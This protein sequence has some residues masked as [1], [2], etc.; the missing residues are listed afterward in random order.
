MVA[1]WLNA[2]AIASLWIALACALYVLVDVV[3]HPQGMA[4]MNWVWPITALYAGPLAVWAYFAWGKASAKPRAAGVAVDVSHCGAGCT[5][6]DIVAESVIFVTGWSIAGS[7]LLAEYVGDYA[8]AYVFGIVFQYFAIAPMRGLAFWPGIWAAIK[9]DT[10]SLTA[11]EIGLFGWMAL[12]N[13][14]LF[15]PAPMPNQ[16]AFWFMMQ[17]GM[18]VGFITAYPMNWWLVRVGI[19][20][21]M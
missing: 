20:E 21:P 7:V 19:K 2:L 12:M 4:I 14:V 8:L 16:P 6:G 15:H 11:F 18:L 10:L 1:P 17:V 3:R 13:F 5:L 9:A